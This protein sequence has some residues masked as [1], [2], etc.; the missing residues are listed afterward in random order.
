MGLVVDTVQTKT[1]K[2]RYISSAGKAVRHDLT[3]IPVRSG[4]CG[5]EGARMLA[6]A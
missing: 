2:C 1:E 3:R 5:D 6:E 4:T